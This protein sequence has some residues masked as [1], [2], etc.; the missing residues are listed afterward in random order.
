M[1]KKNF[2]QLAEDEKFQCFVFPN[3]LKPEYL[4]VMIDLVKSNEFKLVLD[5]EHESLYMDNA[6][7]LV[8][9]KKRASVANYLSKYR[10]NKTY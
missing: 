1:I 10:L 3:S 2:I 4:T 6:K 5:Y 9:F 7:Q 8:I